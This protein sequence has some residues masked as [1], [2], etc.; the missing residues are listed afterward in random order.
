MRMATLF[1]IIIII[2]LIFCCC[3]SFLNIFKFF[4]HHLK[5]FLKGKI[6]FPNPNPNPNS[7]PPPHQS[8][9]E[10]PLSA[11]TAR[12]ALQLT[13][14]WSYLRNRG[15]TS[16]GI[17]NS[18]KSLSYFIP[19]LTTMG[20]DSEGVTYPTLFES[21]CV[22]HVQVCKYGWFSYTRDQRF[23]IPSEGWNSL[24]VTQH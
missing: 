8:I 21:D 19:N 22:L 9:Y 17:L 20:W 3:D 2:I 18:G 1:I 16:K 11:E 6:L 24:M 12:Q 5:F 10:H 15:W 23:N 14:T 13:A 7:L 4:T